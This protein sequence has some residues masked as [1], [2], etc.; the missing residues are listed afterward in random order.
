MSDGFLALL[1]LVFFAITRKL[2][3]DANAGNAH[4]DRHSILMLHN[5]ADLIKN[6]VLHVNFF[7]HDHAPNGIVDG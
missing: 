3:G 4:L 6:L 5:L 2:H 1:M 7:G